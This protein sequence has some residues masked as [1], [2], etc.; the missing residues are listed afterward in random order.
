MNPL[1]MDRKQDLE[2]QTTAPAHGRKKPKLDSQ[3]GSICDIIEKGPPHVVHEKKNSIMKTE[4]K[5][6]QSMSKHY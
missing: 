3:E 6:V 2:I 5:A 1:K 4:I